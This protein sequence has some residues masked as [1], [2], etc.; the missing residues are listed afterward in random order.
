MTQRA[1]ASAC[2]AL[3]FPLLAQ[4]ETVFDTGEDLYAEDG[5]WIAIPA[6]FNPGP[7]TAADILAMADLDGDLT[8]IT[9]EEARMI[10]VLTQVLLPAES[11]VSP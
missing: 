5:P 10:A 2:L 6:D 11:I 8:V 7:L 1:L 4:A 9:E 3:L